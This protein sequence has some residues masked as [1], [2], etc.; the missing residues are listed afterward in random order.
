MIEI[1]V[2]VQGSNPAVF[3]R[4][5]E[6]GPY[7]VLTQDGQ[8]SERYTSDGVTV[9]DEELD[10]AS[11]RDRLEEAANERGYA[12]GVRVERSEAS[13][14]KATPDWLKLINEYLEE[15]KAGIP[16]E[17][18]LNKLASSGKVAKKAAVAARKAEA[19]A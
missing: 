14:R 7:L 16:G 1:S 18:L 4:F 2:D 15:T 11:A 13:H 12:E 19:A 6:R 17:A 3:V 8:V 9:W 10:S 5:G